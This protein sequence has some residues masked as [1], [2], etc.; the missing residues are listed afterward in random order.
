MN[1]LQFVTLSGVPI[2]IVELKWPFHQ[3]TSGSDWYVLHG[4]VDLLERASTDKLHAEVAVAITQTMKEA[5]G[6]LEPQN[7][8]GMAVNAIRKTIDNGQ[9]AFLKSGKLQPV[10]VT[11]R[12]YSFALKK[13]QFPAQSEQEARELIKRRVFWLGTHEA[14]RIAEHYD[15]EY[16]NLPPEKMLEMAGQLAAQGII[17]L[18][19][20]S[21]RATDLL[22][23]EEAE[24]R[25]AMQKGVEAGKSATKI[26][27]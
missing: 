10:H 1:S 7:A 20:D 18:Q 26:S 22:L 14:T 23:K 4:R 19:G 21:A 3:S 6:S 5:L 27:A 9:L 24:I 17:Q 15:C 12:Y 13:V 16:V 2:E 11:S 8:E 25:A